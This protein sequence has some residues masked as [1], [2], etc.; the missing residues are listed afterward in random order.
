MGPE[1]S[2]G[3]CPQGAA[4]GAP[5]GAAL[6]AAP[7]VLLDPCPTPG[8][9]RLAATPPSHCAP[10]RAPPSLPIP[11]PLPT[12]TLG[13]RCR[14][15]RGDDRSKDSGGLSAEPGDSA[16]IFRVTSR[17]RPHLQK[18][19]A[20]TPRA[21]AE[22]SGRLEDGTALAF[23]R[24]GSSPGRP[25]SAARSAAPGKNRAGE[26]RPH[27]TARG[28]GALGTGIALGCSCGPWGEQEGREG[29][30]RSAGQQSAPPQVPSLMLS[31]QGAA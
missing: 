23:I 17:L 24:A 18:G 12:G 26:L 16:P 14:S 13:T 2:A 4:L 21:Q 15:R 6:P 1:P 25:C 20:A 11:A 19:A 22:L 28:L 3:P 8:G 10:Q 7:R 5:T 9:Y 31:L 30:P 29:S 27:G